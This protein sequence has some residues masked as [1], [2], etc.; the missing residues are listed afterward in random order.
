M[1]ATIHAFAL[2]D[3]ASYTLVRASYHTFSSIAFSQTVRISPVIV[4]ANNALTFEDTDKKQPRLFAQ[5]Y[6]SFYHSAIAAYVPER[7][8]LVFE[9]SVDYN[10]G[11]SNSVAITDSAS[12]QLVRDRGITQSLSLTDRA[13]SYIVQNHCEPVTLQDVVFSYGSL[14][15]TIRP[16]QQGDK[17]RNDQ[18]RINR[19]SRAQDLIVF[20]DPIWPKST[21]LS[22]SFTA[23][24]R[25][26]AEE[27]QN[28]V[29]ATAGYPIDVVDFNNQSWKM[30]ILNPTMEIVNERGN[31]YFSLSVDMEGYKT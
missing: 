5:G 13:S 10:K 3:Y 7:D 23:L 11:Y 9:D 6:I 27:F 30:I 2:Y 26:K 20:R 21:L 15:V 1:P 22:W 18:A 12:F 19:R 17:E 25:E 31:C 29:K 16:P 28:F 24:T 8:W 14:S 4:S